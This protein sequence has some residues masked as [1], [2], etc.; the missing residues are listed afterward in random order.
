M[1]KGQVY[2][3]DGSQDGT[4]MNINIDKTKCNAYVFSAH[5]HGAMTGVGV[6]ICDNEIL[7]KMHPSIVGGGNILNI[8]LSLRSFTLAKLPYRHEA[9]TQMVYGPMCLNLVLE[10]RRR[11]ISRC[12]NYKFRY[13]WATMR[14]IKD[15]KFYNKYTPSTRTISFSVGQWDPALLSMFLSKF[16]ICIRSGVMCAPLL[17]KELNRITVCRASLGLHNTFKDVD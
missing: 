12:A 3:L 5:K 1:R 11:F 15:I 8:S 4:D 7:N 2:L 14:T 16:L 9:G 10:W 17:M 13:L 6:N